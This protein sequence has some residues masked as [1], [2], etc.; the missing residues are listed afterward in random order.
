MME[1]ANQLSNLHNNYFKFTN[2]S[3]P[4]LTGM[5]KYRRFVIIF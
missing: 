3:K 2:S 5:K 4:V 1:R